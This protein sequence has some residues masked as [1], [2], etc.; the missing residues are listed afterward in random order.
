MLY[1]VFVCK[2]KLGHLSVPSN[3][4]SVVTDENDIKIDAYKDLAVSDSIES[5]E[6]TITVNR[7]QQTYQKNV[8]FNDVKD[9]L[10]ELFNLNH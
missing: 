10:L 2:N 3:T 9:I 7:E 1:S 4:E 8:V 6:N 5:K